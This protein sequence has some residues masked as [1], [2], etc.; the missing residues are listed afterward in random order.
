MKNRLEYILFLALS[1]FFCLIGLKAARRFAPLLAFIFYYVVPLRKDVVID[2]LAKSFPDWDEQQVK[3]T[4]YGC[5]KSISITL[6]EIL[7]LPS[8][9]SEDLPGILDCDRQELFTKALD[10]GKGMILMTGHFGNWEFAAL[11]LAYQSG[12]P[13]NVVVKPQRNKLVDAW[14]NHYR[15]KWT[16]EIIPL[17]ISIRGVYAAL[18][19]NKA[20]AMVGDQRGP[21]GSI[22]IDF[23]GRP[24][25]AFTGPAALALKSGAAIVMGI[26]VRQPDNTYKMELAEISQEN[27]PVGQDAKVEELTRRHMQHLEHYIRE[28]PEQW[29]WMHK[30]WKH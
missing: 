3:K 9:R 25:T 30:R 23:M 2:N 6:I 12:V 29:F 24:S 18:K 10:K 20:V 27:L 14:M 7:T 4:A 21:E 28:Y 22:R 5:Y 8:L 19:D 11:S 15:T 26:G 1:G 13:F 16:N 17:G